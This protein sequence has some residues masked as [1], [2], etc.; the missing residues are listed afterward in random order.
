MTP[1][2]PKQRARQFESILAENRGRLG[3]LVRV[4]GGAES[5]DLLQEIM[6]QLWRSLSGF[7]RNCQSSTWCYRI[8]LNTAISWKR[9]RTRLK[10]QPPANREPP[11]ML[12][13][14]AQFSDEA[15]LLERFMASLA[16]LDRA[17]LLMYLENIPS[18]EIANA[19]GSSEGAIRTRI[20]RIRKRLE[21]WEAE[22]DR[23]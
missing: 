6:L 16:E 12:E 17:V 20:C 3:R 7:D 8:A 10:R 2:D 19:I 14:E 18:G 9:S 23:L 15:K 5:E 22:D 13:G 4:Y 11:D 21:T 1:K